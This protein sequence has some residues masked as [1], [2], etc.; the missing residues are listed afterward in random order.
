MKRNILIAVLII[1]GMR[2]E[3]FAQ[4]PMYDPYFVKALPSRLDLLFNTSERNIS[5]RHL[6]AMENGA[7]IIF[8][9]S[10]VEDYN[11]I[12]NLDSIIKEVTKKIAFYKDSLAAKD[13]DNVRIDY[14]I[15]GATKR[16]RMRFTPHPRPTDMFISNKGELSRLKVAMDTLRIRIYRPYYFPDK[17]KIISRDSIRNQF[18]GSFMMEAP[19]QITLRLNNYTDISE[20]LSEYDVNQF[21]DSFYTIT[22]PKTKRDIRN[23]R[24]FFGEYHTSAI[25]RSTTKNNVRNAFMR[26]GLNYNNTRVRPWNFHGSIGGA[27]VRNTVAPFAEIG[28]KRKWVW[29]DGVEHAFAAA[30]ITPTFIFEKHPDGTYHTYDNWFVNVEYGARVDEEYLGVK[31]RGG[32]IGGAYLIDPSGSIFKNT[33]GKL[34]FSM[35]LREGLTVTPELIM[36]DNFKSFFP[37]LTIKIF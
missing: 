19:I 25:I 12:R 28:L 10:N 29:A 22:R 9:L 6:V 27:L 1:L 5:H 30:Y 8:E 35:H 21:V 37:G 11:S 2:G 3:A 32:A 31:V 13:Y 17:D 20:M 14:V 34:Y 26:R 23:S 36:T 15:D 7:E 18:I 24:S 16:D 4:Y 33:T